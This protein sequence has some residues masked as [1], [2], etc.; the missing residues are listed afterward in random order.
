MLERARGSAKRLGLSNVEF[1]EGYIEDLPVESNTVDVVISNCV[2]NLSPDKQ[3]VF[4]ET[5]RVL[6]NNEH[7][8]F[9]EYR[10][11]RLVLEAWDKLERGE[12]Y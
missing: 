9:G 6:K 1:R 12:L 8:E 3:R 11:Q 4:A 5:F 2:I 7:A 10:T